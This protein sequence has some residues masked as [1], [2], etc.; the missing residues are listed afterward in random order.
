MVTQP[1]LR[2]RERERE[3][4]RRRGRGSEPR[5]SQ[6]CTSDTTAHFIHKHNSEYFTDRLTDRGRAKVL[7]HC[8]AFT[9]GH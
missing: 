3:R 6:Q 1:H 9:T 7:Q 5:S 4:E 8:I 2:K